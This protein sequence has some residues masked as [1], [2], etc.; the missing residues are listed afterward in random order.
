MREPRRAALG[1]LYAI[2]GDAALA[3]TDLQPIAAFAARRAA[4]ARESCCAAASMRL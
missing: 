2:F 3:M 1:A 4:D